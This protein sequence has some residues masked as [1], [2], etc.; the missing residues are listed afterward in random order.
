MTSYFRQQIPFYVFSCII[1]VMG[2]IFGALAV[3]TINPSQRT[4]LEGH[5]GVFFDIFDPHQKETLSRGAYALE[6]IL[7]NIKA[8]ILAWALGL[9]VIGAPGIPVILFGRGFVLGF[10]VGF[11]V[12]EMV[13]KGVALSLASIFPQNLLIIPAI[14]MACSGSLSLAWSS[15]RRRFGGGSGRAYEETFAVRVIRSLIHLGLAC[16]MLIV[17]GFVEG[18]I[19]P[20]FIK[21]LTR[22][23]HM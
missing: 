5:L 10:T 17:A 8:A 18:Y 2:I 19:T 15:F 4:E 9:S 1:F 11:L 6:S 16:M 3:G 13:F 21:L 14:I 12:E 20:V 23:V 7:G 22:Y